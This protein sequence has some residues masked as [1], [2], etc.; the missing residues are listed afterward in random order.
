MRGCA[1][2]LVYIALLS[3]PFVVLGYTLAAFIVM[4]IIFSVLW[5]LARGLQ[6]LGEAINGED[7][8]GDEDE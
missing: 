7:V 5:L 8:E 4:L 6:A 3:A 1:T 2:L